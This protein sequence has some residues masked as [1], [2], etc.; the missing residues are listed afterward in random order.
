MDDSD[1]NEIIQVAADDKLR[2][3]TLDIGTPETTPVIMG[4]HRFKPK[5][6][7][8]QQATLNVAWIKR[9]ETKRRLDDN[10][11]ISKVTALKNAYFNSI[12]DYKRLYRQIYGE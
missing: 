2:M 3:V 4:N 6:T 5:I 11:D 8:E 9:V 10:G 7:A 1:Y 12:E